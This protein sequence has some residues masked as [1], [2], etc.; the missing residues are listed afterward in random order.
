MATT[1][2]YQNLVFQGLGTISV[3]VP[4]AGLYFVNSQTT[5]PTLSNGGGVSAV[6][7]L[8]K[9][10]GSTQYT[11]VAGATGAQTHVTCAAGDTLALTYS[12]AAAADQGY[13]AV[14]S[15]IAIGQGE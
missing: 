15:T 14:R 12:S 9:L 10:N 2:Y 4:N 13:N 6:V 1:Q 8:V 11:G 5:L 3:V 7:T